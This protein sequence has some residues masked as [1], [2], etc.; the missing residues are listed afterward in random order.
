[1]I[2]FYS[3]GKLEGFTVA[4]SCDGT[5]IDH[6]YIS[7]FLENDLPDGVYTDTLC[8]QDAEGKIDTIRME[9]RAVVYDTDE[10]LITFDNQGI[11]EAIEPLVVEKDITFKQA[12]KLYNWPWPTAEGYV[13]EDWYYDAECTSFTYGDETVDGDMTLYASW[14]RLLDK[15]NMTLDPL[16]NQGDLSTGFTGVTI[17]DSHIA[18]DQAGWVVDNSGSWSVFTGNFRK[19]DDYYLRIKL[20]STNPDYWFDYNANT[21]YV[22]VSQLTLNGVNYADKATFEYFSDW[23]HLTIILPFNF[24][25]EYVFKE[26]IWAADYS[27]ATAYFRAVD[28]S[29]PVQSVADSNPAVTVVKAEDCEN[30]RIVK[31]H[32]HVVFEGNNYET[33]SGNVELANTRLGHNY[34]PWQFDSA[35]RS[36]YRVCSR[37]G[38]HKETQP[39]TFV[40]TVSGNV[41]THECSVCHGKYTEEIPAGKKT[42]RLFGQD[43]YETSFVI[44]DQLKEQLG[45][46]KFANVVIACAT[47]YADALAGSY[48][49][50][51]KNAPIILAGETTKKI[52]TLVNY[53]KANVASGATV[54]VLGGEAAVS[55]NVFKALTDAGL[56]VERVWGDDRYKTNIEIL[57]K[58]G[59]SS[60]QEILVCSALNYADSLS[61]AATGRPILLVKNSLTKKQKE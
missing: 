40:D 54:Y 28:D 6:I 2:P 5:G 27:K 60:S 35:S 57:N 11:G 4:G 49:A 48:L 45:V 20:S 33:D 26:W 36:H 19:G 39:C 16:P 47:N 3:A 34:G 43:R 44:A 50:A 22:N 55:A 53:L 61:A 32:A 59:I 14:H 31:Y 37:D 15:F 52:K 12:K 24:G 21:D 38:S 51:A 30:N 25:V 1:M 46:S 8:F 23:Q 42:T 56:K 58:A 13:F 18:V 10:C 17:A 41:I 29:A 7:L 9:I